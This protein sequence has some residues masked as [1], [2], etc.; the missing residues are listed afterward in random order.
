MAAKIIT[1]LIIALLNGTGGVFI[2]FFLLLA[3]NGFSESDGQWGIYL[4]VAGA[5]IVVLATSVAGI[6]LTKYLI[7]TK[8]WNAALS[9]FFSSTAFVIIGT[10]AD[11]ILIF[12]AIFLAS[13]V[14][15]S[16]LK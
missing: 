3:L 7:E 15:N 16:H 11:F 9:V 13:A 2:L 1:F 14:R 4:Y 5:I 8:N 10:V 12:A 6:F